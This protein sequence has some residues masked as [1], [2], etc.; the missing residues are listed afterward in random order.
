M[1]GKDLG[2]AVVVHG[3]LAGGV[4]LWVALTPPV[5]HDVRVQTLTLVSPPA[6]TE[7]KPQT[8]SVLP[9]ITPPPVATPRRAPV[10]RRVEAIA[11]PV[12]EPT[13]AAAM[14]VVAT[15]QDGAAT[16]AIDGVVD[17]DETAGAGAGGDPPPPPPA[18]PPP[19]PPREIVVDRLAMLRLSWQHNDY[20]SSCITKHI[21]AARTVKT[22]AE[23]DALYVKAR[24]CLDR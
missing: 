20:V 2:L 6:V 13:P 22:L 19:K 12:A 5:R 23:G 14:A 3:A 4:A 11:P 10:R 18:P 9:A 1:R 21:G 7:I 17:G 15:P 16:G 8:A 24:H